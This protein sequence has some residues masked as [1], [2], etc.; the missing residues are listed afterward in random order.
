MVTKIRYQLTA[1]GYVGLRDDLPSI[2]GLHYD[3][4]GTAFP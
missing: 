4:S 3:K 1:G 2:V